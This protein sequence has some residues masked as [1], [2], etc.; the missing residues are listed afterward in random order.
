M[1]LNDFLN[2][3]VIFYSEDWLLQCVIEKVT[4]ERWKQFILS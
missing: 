1:F 2:K 3:F 4:T